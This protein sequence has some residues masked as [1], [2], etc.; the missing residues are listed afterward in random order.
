LIG[1]VAHEATAQ[2]VPDAKYLALVAQRQKE[3][4]QTRHPTLKLEDTGLSQGE[5]NQLAG[6]Y[7]MVNSK[8]GQGVVSS[9]DV[10]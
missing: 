1:K 2:P 7:T 8:F 4:Q 9:F 10:S 3:G 5:M 6:G